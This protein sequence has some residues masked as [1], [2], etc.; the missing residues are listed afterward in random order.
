MPEWPELEHYRA[1]LSPL[2]CGQKIK[3]VVIN[4]SE[5][6]NEPA[7]QFTASLV[8]RIILFF[9]HRGR[10]LLFH[11]DDGN[12]LH[13]DLGLNGW[14]ATGEQE[15]LKDDQYPIILTLEDGNSLRFGGLRQGFLHRVSAKTILEKLKELG[16]D[17]FDSRLTLEAFR[18]RIAGK[19]G[20]LKATLSDQRFLSGIGNIYS[21]EICF[22]AR[23]H[24]AAAVNQ[25]DAAAVENVYESIKRVLLEAAEA[26]GTIE[27]PLTSEDTQTGGYRSV[28]KVYDRQGESCSVCGGEIKYETLA[29]RKMFYCP[30]CQK[31]TLITTE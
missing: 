30:H 1:Q 10:Y 24:P 6:I 16:P 20:K 15:T 21:D 11:L 23:I 9:E 19:K 4:R 26:G 18:K 27:T 2:L 12:R 13:L 28:R 22:E 14:L 25:L 8:D 7:D 17:P 5:F 31:E 29:G 3:S